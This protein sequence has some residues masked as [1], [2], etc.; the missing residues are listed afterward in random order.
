MRW[1]GRSVVLLQ[2]QVQVTNLVQDDW[3]VDDASFVNL[4]Q[5]FYGVVF[6]EVEA[7]NTVHIFAHGADASD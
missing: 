4:V 7:E 3:K 2:K 5:L 1:R 6:L